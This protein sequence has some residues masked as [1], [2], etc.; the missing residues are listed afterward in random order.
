MKLGSFVRHEPRK[1]GGVA[2]LK[3]RERQVRADLDP[4]EERDRAD[5]VRA[6]A[7]GDEGAGPLVA[8]IEDE[9]VQ[10]IVR[11]Q[12]GVPRQ[13]VAEAGPL[14]VDDAVA[15]HR[16]AKAL[17]GKARRLGRART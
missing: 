15:I 12:R 5:E 6:D 4:L 10:R 7:M 13:V 16:G 11:H 8:S 1:R 17:R 14:D 9:R 3:E 2:R